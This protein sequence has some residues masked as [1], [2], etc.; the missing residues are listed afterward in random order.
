MKTHTWDN[1]KIIT[2]IIL[3][4]IGV[5]GLTSG[6]H[7]YV[8]D[9]AA[10]Y[11]MATS[12]VDRSWIDVD[13]HPNT[14]GGKYGPDGRYYMPFGFL[15]PLMAVPLL[16]LGRLFQNWYQTNYLPFFT[17]TWF[18]W[19]MCGLLNA[20][21][22]YSFLQFRV[23]KYIALIIGFAIT[24]STPFWVYSQTFFSEPLTAVLSLSAWLLMYKSYQKN[25]LSI[26]I[27]SGL[28]AG[29]ITWVRPLGGLVIPPLVLYLLLLELK[30]NKLNNNSK[31]SLKP[32]FAFVLAA[33]ASVSVYFYYNWLR[34]GNIFETGYDK[35]PSGLPRSFT[36]NAVTGFNILLF[37]PGKS[38]L[39]FTP[40]LL[41]VPVSI[42]IVVKKRV[43]IPETV[44]S[45]LTGFLYLSV[46]SRWVRIEGGVAWGPRL[47]LPALPILFLSLIPICHQ[48]KRSFYI[49]I[50]V[51]AITGTVIQIPG[52]LVNFSTYITRHQDEYF[53]PRDGQYMFSFNPF[54]G[55][56]AEMKHYI[57]VLPHLEPKPEN[58]T[59][60][61]FEQIN[62]DF[63]LDIWWL[64]MWMDRVPLR[65]IHR[66]LVSLSVLM[67]AGFGLLFHGLAPNI[68]K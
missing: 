55:H 48:S 24:F 35:L 46:L 62:P 21:I 15:Q 23:S 49:L 53:S 60:R 16:L 33:C 57:K 65:F 58:Q 67:L 63:I 56:L 52:I 34:F 64:H 45:L 38:I 25:S 47:F 6:S 28:L 3:I 40:L 4:T 17:V 13:I 18:N 14:H 5:C 8:T 66:M 12:I 30:K 20:L 36:L 9:G 42:I 31:N 7:V 44:F 32:F 37:S 51:L 1:A 22:Y 43:F 11:F 68:R 41:L 19:L 54:P 59:F 39:L 29:M 61:H 27:L 2:G 50:T 26:L 10:M